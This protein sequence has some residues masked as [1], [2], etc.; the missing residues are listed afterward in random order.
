MICARSRVKDAIDEFD[1]IGSFKVFGAGLCLTRVMARMRGAVAARGSG[2]RDA[3]AGA[4]VDLS[5]AGECEMLWRREPSAN[6][7]HAVFT[8]CRKQMCHQM[9]NPNVLIPVKP[10]VLCNQI[11]Y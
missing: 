10:P 4:E 9:P 6:G 11:H 1:Q 2:C 8:L 7:Q 5:S 3:V